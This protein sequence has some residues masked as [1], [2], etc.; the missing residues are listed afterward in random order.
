MSTAAHLS[1]IRAP[2]TPYRAQVVLHIRSATPAKFV[3]HG[4]GRTEILSTPH[5]CSDSL[6]YH[7][8]RLSTRAVWIDEFVRAIFRNKWNQSKQRNT[9]NCVNICNT[10]PPKCHSGHL[11]RCSRIAIARAT[12]IMAILFIT[13]YMV[14]VY[15]YSLIIVTV[16]TVG[17]WWPA[18]MTIK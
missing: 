17:R 13:L 6:R 7:Y 5:F 8:S 3:L 9:N 11:F 1:S 10:D 16:K 14:H 4:G 18:H 2:Y 12:L 15:N